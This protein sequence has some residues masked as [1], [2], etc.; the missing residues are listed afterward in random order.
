MIRKRIFQVLDA[1]APGDHFGR[2]LD[3]TLIILIVISVIA[4]ILASVQELHS[5]YRH[6]FRQ[7]EFIAVVVFS[8]E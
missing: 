7:L 1:P 4:N 6:Q 3:I 8:I 5:Q 2:R